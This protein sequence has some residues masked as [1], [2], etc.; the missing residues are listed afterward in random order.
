MERRTILMHR[1]DN[2]ATA[3]VALTAGEVVNAALDAVSVDTTLVEDIGF[4]HKYALRPIAQGEEVLK[5]GM[6]IGL[7]L[8]D[9]RPGEHVHVHNCRSKRFGYH[10]EHYGLQA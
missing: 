3:L 2:V 8:G 10:R 9:I 4:G 5:Y 1:T 6:P 7:A